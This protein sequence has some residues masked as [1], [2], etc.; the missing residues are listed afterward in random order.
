MNGLRGSV[1]LVVVAGCN[2]PAGGGGRDCTKNQ[3]DAMS[4][5][6]SVLVAS[7]DNGF[8]LQRYRPVVDE[9]AGLGKGCKLPGGDLGDLVV[10]MERAEAD[11]VVTQEEL[12]PILVRMDELVASAT[13]KPLAVPLA[14]DSDGVPTATPREMAGNCPVPELVP[15]TDFP[16]RLQA[17]RGASAT[18]ISRAELI[19]EVSQTASAN[20]VALAQ[21]EVAYRAKT[22]KF[23]PFMNGTEAT[24]KT[25]GV[26]FPRDVKHSFSAAVTKDGFRLLAEGNLDGDPFKDRWLLDYQTKTGGC[27]PAT[28]LAS[29]AINV[30]FESGAPA[31]ISEG[32][33]QPKIKFP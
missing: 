11:K 19:D 3:V 26:K 30:T 32:M 9:F 6:T 28:T 13:G 2:L 12:I 8:D 15:F 29:D 17:L 10:K 14:L 25:L 5:K 23:L 7:G 31:L 22:K 18:D 4:L 16:L 21:A 33:P 24:W 1:V 20:L 27:P